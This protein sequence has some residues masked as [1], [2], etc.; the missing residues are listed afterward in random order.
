MIINK[1]IPSF[2]AVVMLILAGLTG[3]A[4]AQS[5]CQNDTALLQ[6]NS[7]IP[8]PVEYEIIENYFVVNTVKPEEGK[9]SLSGKCDS[10]EQFNEMFHPAAVMWKNQKF[11]PEDYFETHAVVY[12]IQWGNTPWQY[13]V[14]SVLGNNERLV[15]EYTQSG[16][17]S[18][19]ATFSPC[20]LIGVN[21]SAVKSN[22]AI[23]FILK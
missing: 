9:S 4:L 21:K 11:L 3:N 20:L 17:A 23:E 19:S 2:V 18:E 15:I 13:S 10:M 7:E 12:F 5:S 1:L 8:A 16:S 22:P 14:E 6:A